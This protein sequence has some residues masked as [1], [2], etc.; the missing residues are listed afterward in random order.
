MIETIASLIERLNAER[1]KTMAFFSTLT[2]EQWRQPVYTGDPSW[3]PRN[4]L[5]HTVSAEG[6]FLRLFRDVQTGGSGAPLGF[7]ADEFNAAEQEA[8]GDLTQQELLSEFL[9]L[10]AEMTAWV[11][12][13]SNTDLEKTGRH[14]VLGD[15]PL[16]EMIK[17]LT[18]HAH[19]HAR[20]IRRFFGVA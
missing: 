9:R 10:R 4:I 8:L 17:A 11:R 20:D 14:P 16:W 12:T 13:L 3:T 18:L 19:L 15:I 6:E 7:F 1:D 2:V 5:A